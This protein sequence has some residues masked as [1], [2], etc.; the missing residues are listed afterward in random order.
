LLAN[1]KVF[2]RGLA[3][4]RTFK[5]PTEVYSGRCVSWL[6]IAFLEM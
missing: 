3:K 5:V 2:L 1:Q 6:N 4:F